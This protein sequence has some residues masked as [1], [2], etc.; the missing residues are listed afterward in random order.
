MPI[1][2]KN[3]VSY[4]GLQQS[5]DFLNQSHYICLHYI[6]S[7]IQR[8][9]ICLCYQR[10]KSHVGKCLYLT[11]RNRGPFQYLIRVSSLDFTL[12]QHHVII[13]QCVTQPF[14]RD[15]IH[16]SAV[17]QWLTYGNTFQTRS[18]R[19]WASWKDFQVQFPTQLVT[20]CIIIPAVKLSEFRSKSGIWNVYKQ[21]C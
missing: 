13:W 9:D 18:C 16:S 21:H 19:V 11:I 1:C 7:S 10:G 20:P 3:P 4:W 6:P 15:I 14:A 17:I 12:W 5:V 8:V 2:F